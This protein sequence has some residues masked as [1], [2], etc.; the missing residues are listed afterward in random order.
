MTI[1]TIRRVTDLDIS[2]VRAAAERFCARHGI[3]YDVDDPR[4]AED[5]IQ[6]QIDCGGAQGGEDARIKKLWAGC[7]CRALGEPIDVRTTIAWGYV[8]ISID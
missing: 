1:S 2:R 8:G 6:Y 4:G 3:S 7:Y 5:A